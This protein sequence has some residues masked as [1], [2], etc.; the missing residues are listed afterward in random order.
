MFA[1]SMHLRNPS[2]SFETAQRFTR[3]AAFLA[4]RHLTGFSRQ[5]ATPVAT[6]DADQLRDQP[7]STA[8]QTVPL[9]TL[10]TNNLANAVN[11][12][13]FASG[14]RDVRATT[15]CRFGVKISATTCSFS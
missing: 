4:S 2:H 9:S 15:G 3:S 7:I 6:S 5:A 12:L 1:A 10:Q 13:H 11:S 8:G 14:D